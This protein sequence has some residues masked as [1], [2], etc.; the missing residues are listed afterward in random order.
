MRSGS[1]ERAAAFSRSRLPP[2]AD[3]TP[4]L[5]RVSS[6]CTPPDPG[7]PPRSSRRGAIRHEQGGGSVILRADQGVRDDLDYRFDILEDVFVP[8][9]KYAET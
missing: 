5:A 6:S 7:P 8:H 1:F 4:L 9:A 2:P 3:R